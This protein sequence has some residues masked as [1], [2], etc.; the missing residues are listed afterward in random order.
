MADPI[1]AQP[2]L[3]IVPS[4]TY[5]PTVLPTSTPSSSPFLLPIPQAAQATVSRILQGAPTIRSAPAAIFKNASAD[6]DSDDEPEPFGAEVEEYFTGAKGKDKEAPRPMLLDDLI[7]AD[8][9]AAGFRPLVA[10]G[11]PLRITIPAHSA[12]PI[13]IPTSS[14]PLVTDPAPPRALQPAGAPPAASGSGTPRQSQFAKD[15]GF[16]PG[17][18]APTKSKDSKAM[19]N[20]IDGLHRGGEGLQIAIHRLSDELG[21]VITHIPVLHAMIAESTPSAPSAQEIAHHVDIHAVAE[22]IRSRDDHAINSLVTS[23]NKHTSNFNKTIG[24]LQEMD[25]RIAVLPA[26]FSRIAELEAAVNATTSSLHNAHASIALLTAAATPVLAPAPAPRRAPDGDALLAELLAEHLSKPARKRARDDEDDDEGG[27]AARR[28]RQDP[29]LA[30]L[31]TSVSSPFAAI[32]APVPVGPV[33]YAPIAY[34]PVPM[35]APPAPVPAPP[36]APA[37]TP[38]APTHGQPG[39][40]A[41]PPMSNMNGPPRNREVEALFGPV[42]WN[43]NHLGKPNVKQDVS[44]L[45][46]IVLPTLGRVNFTTR[47]ARNSR[48]EYTVLAFETKALAEWVIATWTGASRGDYH[49]ICATT[50]PPNA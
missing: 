30:P 11:V 14:A 1:T 31:P 3:H 36:P 27:R 47:P 4:F 46:R 10:S 37:P 43:L 23:N 17:K 28:Q 13:S 22:R 44:N 9:L 40:P 18:H 49:G 16:T 25:A 24:A 39:V 29:G 35:A 38:A 15:A 19:H 26:L 21:D 20:N 12:P 7:A 2:T 42:V 33:A 34:A 8:L 41:P 48:P 50:P 5:T 45:L 32:P 6:V